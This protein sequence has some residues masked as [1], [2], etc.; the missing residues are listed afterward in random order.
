M[1]D[2]VANNTVQSAS[3][4]KGDL[5]S[6]RLADDLNQFLN[7][8]VTQLE[9]QDPLDPLDP[10]EFTSQLVQFAS[11]E[12]QIYQNQNLEDMLELQQQSIMGD[13]VSYIG[14][15]VEVNGN[16]LP[17]ENGIGQFQYTL[18]G[19][20]RSSTITIS[21][22]SGQVVFFTAGETDA[23]SHDAVWPGLDSFGFPLE[24]GVYTV[25]VSAVD[26]EG[27]SINVDTNIIGT[28]KGVSMEDGQVYVSLTGAEYK[29]E[30]VISVRSQLGLQRV[31]DEPGDGSGG[32]GTSGGDTTG[33]DTTT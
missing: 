30:D 24:D 11:V 25:N 20:A 2:A 15:Q 28:V 5:A 16:E 29:L 3:E 33:D 14:A 1:L 8:L 27:N 12:Q 18:Q 9:N 4:T 22:E 6:Q 10:N 26:T 23:G 21:D 13:V 19:E 31:V 17:L 7:L 32:D